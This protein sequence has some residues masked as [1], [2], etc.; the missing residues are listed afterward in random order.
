MKKK[1]AIAVL[2]ICV[3]SLVL[4]SLS[5]SEAPCVIVEVRVEA[6]GVMGGYVLFVMGPSSH[7]YQKWGEINNGPLAFNTAVFYV[8]RGGMNGRISQTEA[9]VWFLRGNERAI[10]NLP[11]DKSMSELLDNGTVVSN[12]SLSELVRGTHHVRTFV[13]DVG[14]IDF[15]TLAWETEFW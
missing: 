5:F 8:D 9:A 10:F 6:V 4:V 12:G 1:F 7:T 14:T 3:A 13:L 15:T 2:L 11:L